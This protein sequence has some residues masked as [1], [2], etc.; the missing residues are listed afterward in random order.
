MSFLLITDE[1]GIAGIISGFEYTKGYEFTKGHITL[2]NNKIIYTRVYGTPD[3]AFY[4]ALTTLNNKFENSYWKNLPK[5]QTFEIIDKY[6]LKIVDNLMY[7]GVSMKNA[8]LKPTN[9]SIMFKY[10]EAMENA[11]VN[12]M[13]ELSTSSFQIGELSKAFW[14]D[15]K[16]RIERTSILL[17]DD[18]TTES[19][20]VYK[21]NIIITDLPD[22]SAF[23]LGVNVRYLWLEKDNIGNWRV[24]GLLTSVL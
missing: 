16:M 14:R 18:L 20:V 5:I 10:I 12:K 13:N 2:E 22:G 6:T 15:A 21:L 8:I 11:D 4:G 1:D 19:Q 7:D 24:A 9:Q 3:D 23:G 17:E